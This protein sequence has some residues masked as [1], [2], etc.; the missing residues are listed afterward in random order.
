EPARFDVTR[1]NA[2]DHL[3]FSAGVHYCVGAGLARLEGVVGLRALSDR[4]PKL[5]VAGRPVR[6]DLR[7]L[8][9]FEHLPVALR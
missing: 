2:R 3:A 4:F 8:R 5:R 1:A 6:R 7:T 9:G